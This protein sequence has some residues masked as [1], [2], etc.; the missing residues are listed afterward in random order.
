MTPREGISDR[1]L[2]I[3]AKVEAFVRETIASYET[4]RRRDHHGAPTDELVMEMRERAR[5]A[6]VL[7]PHILDDGSHPNQSE[8][9]VVLIKRGLSPPGPPP[10]TTLDPDASNLYLTDRKSVV[11][12]KSVSVRED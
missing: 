3:A 6:G 1:A 12:G 7:T 8:T 2:A 10:C 11:A 9:A 5:A 4:D